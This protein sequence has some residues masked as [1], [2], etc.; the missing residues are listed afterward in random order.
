MNPDEIA[1]LTQ[2][3]SEAQAKHKK[4]QLPTVRARTGQIAGWQRKSSGIM[5]G[6]GNGAARP[7]TVPGGGMTDSSLQ[8]KNM[9]ESQVRPSDVTDRRIARAMSELPREE[10]VPREQRSLAYKDTEIVVR[11]AGP[12][13][14]ARA[15]IEPR[16]LAKLVQLCSIEP[17]DV[18]LVVGCTTGYT[19]AV[20]ARLAQTVVALE[21][22]DA[23]VQEATRALQ[24][25]SIDNVAVVQGPLSSGYPSEGPYDVILIDGGVETV[26]DA[27]LGQLK[28]GGRLVA[29]V[30]DPPG[31]HATVWRRTT[32][33]LAR[34]R[35]FDAGAPRLPGFEKAQGFVF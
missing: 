21:A 14:P 32:A 17:T 16:V 1:H 9:V 34:T 8:R 15:L 30:L 7:P 13:L 10:F 28:Q 20:V 3:V 4:C 26:P 24:A 12:G 25:L 33:A 19:A 11:R 23:L 27:I 22:E 29:V 18:A 6:A 35:E 5:D 2:V 31:G